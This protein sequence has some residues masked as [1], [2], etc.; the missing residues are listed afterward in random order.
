ME[1]QWDIKYSIRRNNV[2]EKVF[3]VTQNHK[4]MDRIIYGLQTLAQEHVH[5]IKEKTYI[6]EEL[7][8]GRSLWKKYWNL[9]K[10][11]KF[12]IGCLC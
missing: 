7:L 8:V 5:C 4:F 9:D 1:E 10:P 3:I 11:D 12:S 6:Q 2:G